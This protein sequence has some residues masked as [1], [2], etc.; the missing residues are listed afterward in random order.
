MASLRDIIYEWPLNINRRSNITV[1][2]DTRVGVCPGITSRGIPWTKRIYAPGDWEG[3]QN[4]P[5]L[6]YVIHFKLTENVRKWLRY[7]TSFML[8]LQS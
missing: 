5:K 2:K 3:F 7:V 6:Y 8:T 4:R 1:C